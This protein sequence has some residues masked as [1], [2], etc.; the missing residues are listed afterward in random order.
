MATALNDFIDAARN[1]RKASC[2]IEQMRNFLTVKGWHEKV[3]PIYFEPLLVLLDKTDPQE[4][5]TASALRNMISGPD[6]SVS[7]PTD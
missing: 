2:D 7:G 4:V 6:D 5:G 3:E 1:L